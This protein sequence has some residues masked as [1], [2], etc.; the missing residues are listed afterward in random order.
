MAVTTVRSKQ[1]LTITADQSFGNFKITSLATPTASTDAATKGYVDAVKTGLDIKDSVRLASTAN[2]TITYSAT[3]GTSARGQ[4]TAAPNTL[5]GVNLA[6]NDRILL[7][8]QSTGA[9]N[10]IYVVSTLGTGSNGVWDRATDF[11][12]DTEVTAGAFVFVEEGTQ[13][14]NGYVLTTNNPITIGGASGTALAWAQFSGAGQITAGA[15]LTKTGNTLDVAVDNSTIEVNAD[16]LRVKDAGITFAKI[17]NITDAR[18]LGRS[19]GSAGSAQE[20]TIGSGLLL[21][22]GTLSSTA[23]GGSV[24]SVSVVTANGF[25]GTVATANSTPAITLTTTITGVLKGNGTAI[26]AAVAGT[27]YQ[28]P[29]T[30]TT[31]G[32]SGAA[33]FITNTLN[34]PTY[35]LAGLGGFANPM[36]TLGDIIYGGASGAATR[37]GGNSTTTPQFLNSTGTGAAAAAPA[38]TSST[39]SGNVVLATSASISTPTITGGTHTA[40]TSLGIR[41]TSA[42]FDVTI[43]AVSSTALTA[44]RTLTIN[45]VNAARTLKLAGNIDIAGNLTL[46]GAFSTSGAFSVALTATA[47]TTLTLPTSGTLLST[48]SFVTR[49]TPS[50]TINGSNAAFTLANTPVSGSERVYV[51]GVLQNAGAGN[52]YTIST[53]TITF[54]SGAIPQT[55]DV[56]LVNYLK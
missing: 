9:Q 4:I 45:M 46:A 32:S 55:G 54:Q 41:D 29:I 52:D 1:Q 26:S 53:N 38:W 36:T 35:T 19:A 51:N 49:E 12:E 3:G 6:A 30:L 5:D 25:A 10:G 56:I 18:L 20:I 16:A 28:A 39:G 22:G 50:G 43:A 8:D 33:T 37:L 31:T 23:G 40:L 11:D 7:K 21:S 2:I 24:T 47:S 34:I 15:A 48:A 14:D 27:D 42:A 13:A 44:G 17:Q